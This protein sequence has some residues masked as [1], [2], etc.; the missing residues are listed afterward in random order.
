L[1]VKQ[2]ESWAN[3]VN[4]ALEKAGRKERVDHRS[5]KERGIDRVPE[6]K[7]GVAASAMKRRGAEPDPKRFQLIRRVKL[8]NDVRP[9]MRALRG[10]GEVK[11]H[12]MG[13]TWWERSTF[14]LSRLG[15][16]AGQKVAS[17]WAKLLDVRHAK[18]RTVEQEHSR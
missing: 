1:L 17:A 12:G 15:R 11:Q 14:M 4:A 3:A 16:K 13:R 18:G 8:L 7:I 10:R 9:L 2:R 6:P 5:L